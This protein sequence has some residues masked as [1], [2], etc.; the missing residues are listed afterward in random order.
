MG[1]F[2]IFCFDVCTAVLMTYSSVCHNKLSHYF[3]K[4]YVKTTSMQELVIF[5]FLPR[6]MDLS[7]YKVVALNKRFYD[8]N[9]L[10]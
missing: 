3:S 5:H 2:E 1:T 7:D 10:F 6:G 9:K 4:P 8:F